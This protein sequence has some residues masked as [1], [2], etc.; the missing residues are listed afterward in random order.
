VSVSIPPFG[1]RVLTDVLGNAFRTDDYGAVFVDAPAAVVSGS[2]TQST[3]VRGGTYGLFVPSLPTA[4]SLGAGPAMQLLVPPFL[5]TGFRV[6]VG[7]TETAGSPATV[8]LSVKD[9]RGAPKG[10]V[11]RTVPPFGLTQVND[12]YQEIAAQ[13]DENDRFE[14]RVAGGSGKVVAYATSVDNLTNDGLLVPG[15]SPVPDLIVPAAAHAGG[16]YG[17]T[18]RTDLK[19]ANPSLTPI[20]IKFSYFPT[21]GPSFAP[22]VLPLGGNETKLIRDVLASLFSP[23]VDV[24]GA[25]RLTVLDGQTVVASSRTYTDTAGGSYGLAIS[26]ADAPLD[27]TPGR[28]IALTFL[29]GS[30]QT[31]TNLGFL[32]TSGRATRTRISL[33]AANGTRLAAKE[34]MFAAFEAVQWNDVFAQLGIAPRDE[35]SAILEVL[36]GGSVIAHAIQIDNLTNDA[37]F[38]P[39]QLLP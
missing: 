7:F 37:S 23:T 32:E 5:S 21:T 13:Q 12:I 35:A 33:Y 24:S 2:R 36:E 9:K 15:A 6:N 16:L 30:A 1:T 26:P 20:R 8:E 11:T 22:V 27:A 28:R 4:A 10:S 3:A 31:R 39:G 34:L 38:I 17:A 18:F 14:V 25:L 29:S 19:L